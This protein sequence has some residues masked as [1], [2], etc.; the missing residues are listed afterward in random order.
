MSYNAK[1]K[2][3]ISKEVKDLFES[4]NKNVSI[5][6]KLHALNESE[7]K[8]L[9]ELMEYTEKIWS[10]STVSASDYHNNLGLSKSKLY[11]TIMAVIGTSPNRFLNNYRL[12][13]AL[14]KL[15]KKDSN[16]S[17]VAYSSGFSSPSYFS[18]SFLKTYGILPSE[19]VK[20]ILKD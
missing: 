15:K 14:D 19:Y 16:I 18:K 5:G 2:I 10:D 12:N 8:F 9:I 11:R 13:K 7:E 1:N 6:S 4:E 20:N 17:E 3:T